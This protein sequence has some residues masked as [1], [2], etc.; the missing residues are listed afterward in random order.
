MPLVPAACLESA[1]PRARRQPSRHTLA[2]RTC[3]SLLICQSPGASIGPP[4][5]SACRHAKLTGKYRPRPTR[6][7]RTPTRRRAPRAEHRRARHAAAVRHGSVA[8]AQARQPRRPSALSVNPCRSL[9]I[10]RPRGSARNRRRFVK[11]CKSLLIPRPPAEPVRSGEGSARADGH[12]PAPRPP[13]RL[14]ESGGRP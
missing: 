14:V 11:A 7:G 12:R 13:S 5:G 1:V 4:A 10:A 2:G 9:L 8:T 6:A 3:K